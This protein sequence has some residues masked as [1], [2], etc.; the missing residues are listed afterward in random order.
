MAT[1]NQLVR[2]ATKAKSG[3]AMFLR[4]HR[5]LKNVVYVLVYTQLHRRSQTQH[6]V[7]LRVCV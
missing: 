7:K 1:V 6:C 3:R 4:W 2:K 5:A